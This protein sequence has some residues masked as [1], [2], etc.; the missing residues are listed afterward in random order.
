MTAPPLS[1]AWGCL[2]FAVVHLLTVSWILIVALICISL[3]SFHVDG[4]FEKI[5][6]KYLFKLLIFRSTCVS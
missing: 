2:T 5:F 1:T 6:L 3:A 4:L